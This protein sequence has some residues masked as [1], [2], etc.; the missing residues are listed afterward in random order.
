MIAVKGKDDVQLDIYYTH[1]GPVMDFETLRVLSA[2]LKGVKIPKMEGK[3]YYSLAQAV[4][5][6][7]VDH[8][9][10]AYMKLHE[11][12][13]VKDFMDYVDNVGSEGWNGGMTNISLADDAGNIGYV[14]LSSLPVRS[15]DT[16]YLGQRVLDGRKSDFD[17]VM[18]RNVPVTD[19]PRSFNPER[20]YIFNSNNRPT[21]DTAKY[22]YGATFVS[23]VR[24]IRIQNLID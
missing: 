15:D 9:F 7:P 11:T 2:I 24:S 3:T 12:T 18:D 8:S 21:P 1:R 22:D 6:M 5:N 20:G 17:W 23:T 10:G 4:K 19:L 16:P 13:S 14:L